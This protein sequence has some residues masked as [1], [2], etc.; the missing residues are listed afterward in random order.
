MADSAENIVDEDKVTDE[1]EVEKK[2][3]KDV[4]LEEVSFFLK[5]FAILMFFYTFVFGHYKIPSE[6][7][8]PTLE[9]GDHLYVSKLAYGYSKHSVPL[10][11]HNHFPFDGQIFSRLPKRGDVAVFRN[12]ISGIVMIKRV[13]GLPGDQIMMRDGRAFLNGQLIERKKIE[14]LQYRTENQPRGLLYWINPRTYIRMIQGTQRHYER[15]GHVQY[16]ASYWEQWPDEDSPHM[17]YEISDQPGTKKFTVPEGHIFFMGDNR[18][19]SLDSRAPGGPGYVPVEYL[20]GRAD[21]MLFSF[22][23]CPDEDGIYCPPRR[24]FKKL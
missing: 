1:D 7:M 13:V 14:E 24:F 6:S 20:I 15:W 10:G 12:P 9:V 4:I 11:L 3:A 22:K 16:S 2:S 18:D 8:Q 21:R 17:I 19:R 23:K 5:L